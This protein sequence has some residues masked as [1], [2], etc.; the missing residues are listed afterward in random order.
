M[1]SQPPPPASITRWPWWRRW[2]GTRSERLAAKFLRHS[3]LRIL[4]QNVATRRNEIDL[5]AWDGSTQE[6]VIVEVRST[7]SNTI[8]RPLASIDGEKIR[9]LT[10]AA[11]QFL[12]RHRLFGEANVRFDVLAISWPPNS[13]PDIHHVRNA[14]EATGRRQMWN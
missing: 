14:F 9:K 12:T 2:F 13:R 3:G 11:L 8:E 5:I 1:A 10:Q 6:I 7:S 4:A